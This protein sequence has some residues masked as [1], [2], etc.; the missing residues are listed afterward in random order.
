MANQLELILEAE[1]RGLSIPQEKQSLLDEARRRGL[2][3][4]L[5]LEA[6][7]P[8]QRTVVEQKSIERKQEAVRTGKRALLEEAPE[9]VGGIVG[10][11]GGAIVGGVPGAIIGAGVG[12]AIGETISQ[13]FTEEEL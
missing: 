11:V 12:G 3:P 7:T 6:L 9:T 4:S 13:L 1:K 5:G 10:G 8:E 2:V